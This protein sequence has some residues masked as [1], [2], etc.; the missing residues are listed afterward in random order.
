MSA[1][2]YYPTLFTVKTILKSLFRFRVSGREKIPKTGGIII[3]ANHM[4]Y[5]DPPV[6]AAALPRRLTFLAKQELFRFAPFG[7]YISA[8]GA[9]PIDR[10]R[11]DTAAIR[12]AVKLLGEGKAVLVFP[13]GGRNT[14]G[15]AEAKNGVA[16]LARMANV[17]VI[18]AAI[19]G[20]EATK[21]LRPIR[22]AF[23]DP[24]F[25]DRETHKGQA[26]LAQLRDAVMQNIASLK[27]QYTDPQR[28][29]HLHAH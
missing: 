18:P 11:G 22:V 17:P 28:S 24:I 5:F 3:A 8:L 14:D 29:E 26:G 6:M 23:G 9:F 21:Q 2:A 20:T 13:E 7:R 16:L 19:I 27:Q 10:S 12:Y 1:F 4:S 25:Y 15:S